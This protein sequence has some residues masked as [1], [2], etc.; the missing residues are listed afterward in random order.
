MIC[1]KY[2]QHK[3]RLDS[4]VT[5]EINGVYKV[6]V[7]HITF[8]NHVKLAKQKAHEFNESQRKFDIKRN[9]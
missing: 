5:G 4:I 1:R 2:K 9:N 6:D 8:R 7:N 3:K